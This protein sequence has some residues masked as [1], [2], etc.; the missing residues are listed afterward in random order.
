MNVRGVESTPNGMITRSMAT[1]RNRVMET[2]VMDTTASN[3]P[4]IPVQEPLSTEEANKRLK[5][6]AKRGDLDAVKELTHK[7]AAQLSKQDV[8]LAFAW[9]VEHRDVRQFLLGQ[10]CPIKPTPKWVGDAF[11]CAAMRGDLDAVNDILSGPIQPT[12]KWV[13]VALKNAVKNGHVEIVQKIVQEVVKIFN[14]K[15]SPVDKFHE[16]WA[17]ETLEWVTLSPTEDGTWATPTEEGAWATMHLEIV[18][19]LLD[20]AMKGDLERVKELI[21]KDAAQ[22][23]EEDLGLVFAWSVEHRDVR[24]F[25][26]GQNCPIKPGPKWVGDAF[27]YAAMKG[28]L[29]AVN[30]I[31]SGPIQLDPKFVRDALRN[32]AKNGHAEIVQEIAKISPPN[33]SPFDESREN[34]PQFINQCPRRSGVDKYYKYWVSR[35]LEWAKRSGHLEI[36]KIFNQKDF[37]VNYYLSGFESHPILLAMGKG[38]LNVLEHLLGQD[39]P[40]PLGR[41]TSYCIFQNFFSNHLSAIQK[42]KKEID[43]KVFNFLLSGK[44]W[45]KPIQLEVEEVRKNLKGIMADAMA[46]EFDI[47][48][49]GN[50]IKALIEDTTGELHKWVILKLNDYIESTGGAVGKVLEFYLDNNNLP[51]NSVVKLMNHFQCEPRD[52]AVVTL[53]LNRR[54]EEKNGISEELV[55]RLIPPQAPKDDYGNTMNVHSKMTPKQRADFVNSRFTNQKLAGSARHPGIQLKGGQSRHHPVLYTVINKFIPGVMVKD[56][57]IIDNCKKREEKQ[58]S[59][60]KKLDGKIFHMDAT[61]GNLQIRENTDMDTIHMDTMTGNLQIRENTDMDTI[62]MDT[63]TGNLQ[64]RENTDMDTIHMDTMTGSAQKRQKTDHEG[65]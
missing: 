31:L 58:N 30:D 55:R 38:H 62:H 8:G 35:A 21:H 63:T 64:I 14:P 13:V 23:S 45:A 60:K 49:A 3:V 48:T 1:D 20:A 44:C 41:G 15:T 61:T 9:S 2:T 36:V 39:Y 26:L 7:Y 53:L 22:L 11:A 57:K 12:Q 29:D 46:N 25:L 65:N 54:L 33:T 28:D 51:D 6:A 19:N 5:D 40:I 32:A 52:P 16:Y 24:Q 10:E 50:T 42:K 43:W 37:P 56:T 47:E 27:A 4:R 59:K 34:L 18:K 17:G